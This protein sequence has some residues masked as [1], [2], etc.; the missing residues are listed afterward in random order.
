MS[1]LLSAALS[2]SPLGAPPPT[3]RDWPWPR[4]SAPPAA[5]TRD[6]RAL[7][8]SP[9]RGC[10]AAPRGS[11]ARCKEEPRRAGPRKTARMRGVPSPPATAWTGWSVP[12]EVRS[13]ARPAAGALRGHAPCARAHTHS[14]THTRGGSH[15]RSRRGRGLGGTEAEVVPPCVFFWSLDLSV[16]LQGRKSVQ[17]IYDLCAHRVPLTERDRKNQR[18]HVGLRELV[19]CWN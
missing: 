4:G 12:R 18:S 10:W 13:S 1:L 19:L 7:R 8:A 17:S 14:Q 9:S 3:Q 15:L 11:P 5:L 6:P 2:F 16:M